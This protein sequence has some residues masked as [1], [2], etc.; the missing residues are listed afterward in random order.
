MRRN[1]IADS[2][3]ELFLD[4]LHRLSGKS[5]SE[6]IRTAI[7]EAGNRALVP[8]FIQN[9]RLPFFTLPWPK[10]M[11]RI[12]SRDEIVKQSEKTKRSIAARIVRS[13][14]R[15]DTYY[16]KC[17]IC[18]NADKPFDEIHLHHEDYNFP[19][20]ITPLCRVHH[21]Q[22]HAFLRRQEGV[23][24]RPIESVAQDMSEEI[25]LWQPEV[26][27]KSLAEEI[28][29]IMQEAEKKTPQPQKDNGK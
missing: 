19:E 16:L 27:P 4:L 12:L 20:R 23:R 28:L 9:K 6:V 26:E 2:E 14:G 13:S 21:S 3:T 24:A 8:A 25:P 1:F 10:G 18:N 29:E 15:R 17:V 22:R 5:I 7:V 11:P